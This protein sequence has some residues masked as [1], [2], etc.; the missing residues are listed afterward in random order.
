MRNTQA[1]A[2]DSDRHVG[3]RELVVVITEQ[4]LL[5]TFHQGLRERGDRAGEGERARLRIPTYSAASTYLIMVPSRGRAKS[6]LGNIT[7]NAI[8]Y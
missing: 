1:T 3:Q 6:F 5:W 7:V 8:R 4:R 2:G